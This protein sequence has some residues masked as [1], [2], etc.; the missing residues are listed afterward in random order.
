MKSDIREI[1]SGGTYLVKGGFQV[2]GKVFDDLDF[3]EIK[4][5][6]KEIR[7][8]KISSVVVSGIYSVVNPEQVC[9][10]KRGHQVCTVYLT[11]GISII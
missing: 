11:P 7:E 9:M 6:A 4:Q 10:I 5:V 2:N 1:L 8:S 3:D